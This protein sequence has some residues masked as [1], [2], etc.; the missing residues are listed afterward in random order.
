LI[1]GTLILITAL[2]VGGAQVMLYKLLSHMNRV[3]FTAEVVSL[4]D[5][6]PFGKKIQALGVPVRALGMRPGIPN[7]LGIYRLA[8]W[9]R[10]DRPHLVQTW[11]Y[12]ADLIGGL[13]ARLAGGI[14]VAWNIR[15]GSPD[16]EGHKR[17]T[18][19]TIRAC[20]TLSHWLPTWIVCCAEFSRRVYTD[21]GYAGEKIVVIPNGF[22]LEI[23]RPDPTARLSVRRELGIPK[24]TLLIGLVGRFHPLKDHSNFIDA[25]ARLHAELPEVHF[26]LCGE[27]ITPE[28]TELAERVKT[29]GIRD[30]CH[31]LGQRED[32]PR[33]NAALDIACSSSY[34]EG[35][36]NVIGEAMACG[37][38]CVVTDVGDSARLVGD[39]GIVVPPKN[40][41]A[42]A[43]AWREL[44][45]V[46]PDRRSLLGV[47]ARRRVSECFSLRAVAARYEELYT[48]IV[49][50]AS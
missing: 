41:Q 38:P 13:A 14:P 31:L 6:G 21:L 30:R 34:T 2:P 8:R 12:H 5:V 33:I 32:I 36:P 28:N 49:A 35:F 1:R 50:H 9:L 37:I 15:H 23:F 16:V 7:P 19:W 44:I 48:E 46:G 22:D 43:N 11:M 25:A 40:P 47:A 24:E 29:S 18:L 26:L 27:D 39:T 3:D 4:V 20:A 10:Q 17:T 42:L 45:E